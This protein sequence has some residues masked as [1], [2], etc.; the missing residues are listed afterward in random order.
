MM[1]NSEHLMECMARLLCLP[2]T[3]LHRD[4][5]QTSEEGRLAALDYGK[6]QEGGVIQE[7]V[8]PEG[9]KEEEEV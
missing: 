8:G 2:V 4:G 9:S 6:E 3:L 5:G 1:H 7:H